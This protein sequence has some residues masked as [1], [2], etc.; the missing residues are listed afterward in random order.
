MKCNRICTITLT[1]GLLVLVVLAAWMAL[2]ATRIAA[3]DSNPKA[4]RAAG[5]PLPVSTVKAETGNLESLAAAEC[6]A[7]PSSQVALA[8]EFDWRVA[9]VKTALGMA[10]KKD[11]LLL[12]FENTY[13]QDELKNVTQGLAVARSMIGE[14]EPLLA[15]V[16]K[17]EKKKLVPITDM[18]RVVKDVGQARMDMIRSSKDVIQAKYKLAK[19]ELHAPFDGVVTALNVETGATPQPFSEMMTISRLHPIHLECAFAETDIATITNHDKIETSFTAYPGRVFAAQFYQILPEITEDTPTLNVL[20]QLA[21]QELSFLPGMHAIV[22][23]SK[24]LEGLRIP[25]ISLIKPEGSKAN[26]FVIDKAGIARL[27]ALEIGRYAQGYVQVLKGLSAGER[28]V[29][30]GQLYLQDG[31]QVRE[32]EQADR[33][34][35]FP[36]L[37]R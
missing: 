12:T 2:K 34:E 24:H 25:A 19:T 29:V 23:L 4:A 22:R 36:I 1:L 14:L 5:K 32:G 20:F 17:L 27:R 10:V 7:R 9:E 15:D 6:V 35:L 28:V 8:T 31:D 33:N 21:N 30:A 18:L 11:Q 3:L 26:A 16:R 37:N 13:I